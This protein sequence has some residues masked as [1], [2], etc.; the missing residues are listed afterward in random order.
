[1]DWDHKGY[2]HLYHSRDYWAFKGGANYLNLE[3]KPHPIGNEHFNV[4]NNSYTLNGDHNATWKKKGFEKLTTNNPQTEPLLRV[5][6]LN[7]NFDDLRV[8][9]GITNEFYEGEVVS[10]MGP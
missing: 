6:D 1:M 2:R 7:K 9:K 4:F 5:V 8:L 3:S 10:I